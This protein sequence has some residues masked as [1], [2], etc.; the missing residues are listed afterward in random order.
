M[1]WFNKKLREYYRDEH[2][3]KVVDIV[4]DVY[5]L[6]KNG[7][8]QY[9]FSQPTQ[10]LYS[11]LHKESGSFLDKPLD[12]NATHSIILE[13]DSPRYVVWREK[14]TGIIRW[15]DPAGVGLIWAK[16]GTA[17]TYGH[18]HNFNVKY[19][20]NNIVFKCSC[21]EIKPLAEGTDY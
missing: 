19:V 17:A 21:G 8:M 13:H 7:E 11:S 5:I 20:E 6:F 15:T 4:L 2:G 12:P 16:K 18:V 3:N 14:E 10:I 1:S 9:A